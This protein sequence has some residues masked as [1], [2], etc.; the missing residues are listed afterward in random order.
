MKCSQRQIQDFPK[1]WQ[2]FNYLITS[3]W[4]SRICSYSRAPIMWWLLDNSHILLNVHN[5]YCIPPH[6]LYC[7]D[8]SHIL[9]NSHKLFAYFCTNYPSSTVFSNL[10]YCGN[11]VSLFCIAFLLCFIFSRQ[12]RLLVEQ[13]IE[14]QCLES[15][16][17]TRLALQLLCQMALM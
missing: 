16:H 10:M 1:N 7:M 6:W 17:S 9:L 13:N 5:S 15:L 12:S 3:I 2:M 11:Y 4:C 14:C 8:N